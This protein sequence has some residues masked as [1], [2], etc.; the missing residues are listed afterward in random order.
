[1]GEGEKKHNTDAQGDVILCIKWALNEGLSVTLKFTVYSTK[2]LYISE[3]AKNSVSQI[4]HYI[5]W[6]HS[7]W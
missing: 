5:I 4:S 2:V 6:T 1:M 7:I 3:P